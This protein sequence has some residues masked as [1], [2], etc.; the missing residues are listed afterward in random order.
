MY[1]VALK[2]YD[3]IFPLYY[4]NIYNK[5]DKLYVVERG[6]RSPP[7]KGIISTMTH[8][9]NPKNIKKKTT[10]YQDRKSVV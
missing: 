6:R 5:C 7:I 9:G 8:Y 10:I 1:Y 4:P 3:S 2:L